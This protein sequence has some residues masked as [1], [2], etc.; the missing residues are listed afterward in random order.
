[1]PP[2][3]FS[4]NGRRYTR[5]TNPTVVICLDGCDP[6]YLE[7]VLATGRVPTLQRWK[8]NGLWATG[9]SV[10]PSFT[11]PNNVS[12]ITGVPPSWHG[13][14]GN[15]FYDSEQGEEVPMNRRE[16]LRCPTILEALHQQGVSVMTLTAKRKLLA[17]LSAGL[18]ERGLAAENGG[19]RIAAL[20]GRKPPDIYSADISLFVLDAALGAIEGGHADFVYATTTDYVQ[21]KHPPGSVEARAFYEAIDE[22]LGRL[23]A[24]GVT[25]AVT[26]D[27]GMSDKTRADGTPQV[28]Y[29]GALFDTLPEPRPRVTLP[30]TDPYVAHHGSL[31]SLAMVYLEG[32]DER[33]VREILQ[34]D[35]GVAEVLA[36]G[37]AAA[38]FE[39]PPDRIG[40]L[41]VLAAQRVVLGKRPEDHD[42][43]EVGQGLRS[44]GGLDEQAVP[45]ILNRPGDG[46][47]LRNYDVFALALS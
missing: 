5:P 38:R 15:H 8:E 3:T 16:Q 40:D 39:L 6:E 21:H 28:V 18:G 43:S 26:A 34:N 31:G 23:D 1:M 47:N 24:M 11:N 35:E 37:E 12:I 29:L 17:L 13:I 44:H 36:R 2:V 20:A 14:S 22:R 19:A 27:H 30:I 33:T 9:R 32:G 4:V 42:L 45:V 7:D 41:V 10:I 46:A 25:V